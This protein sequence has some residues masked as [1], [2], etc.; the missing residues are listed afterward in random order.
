MKYAKP[1][2]YP[3][4]LGIIAILLLGN[5]IPV[6]VLREQAQLTIYSLPPAVI[7]AGVLLNGLMAILFKHTANYLSF[8]TPRKLFF[9]DNPRTHT[10]EYERK[11]RWMALIYF[12]AITFYIPILYFAES[13]PQAISLS[14][15]PLFLPQVIY[16]I[17]GIYESIQDVKTAKAAEEREARERREQ[18]Q[19]E[20]LGIW[21]STNKRR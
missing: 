4:I 18:E 9:T 21:R 17:H 13:H 8:G 16:I 5:I 3:L 2:P 6:L 15:I 19:R 12:G 14:L 7:A 20:E 11:F 10:P 1:L